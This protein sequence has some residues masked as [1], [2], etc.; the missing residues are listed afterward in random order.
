MNLVL[1]VEDEKMIRQGI[2]TMI[3]RSGVPVDVIM[4]CN[5]GQ[6]ALEILQEQ[7]VDVMFTDIRMPKVDGIE[8]VKRMQECEHVPL[9]VAISGYD[10]FS[11]AVELMR[12]GVREYL[13][14]P[15]DR[16][17]LKNILQKLEE[18]IQASKEFN[19]NIRKLGYQQLK[20]LMMNEHMSDEE[21]RLLKFQY[22]NQFYKDQYYVM[23]LENQKEDIEDSTEYIYL[24]DIEYNDVFIVESENLE[25][26]LKN[27][28]SQSCVGISRC[29]VG[30]Q[31]LKEAYE[32][33]S[34]AR[35]RAF[36][37]NLHVVDYEEYCKKKIV[38]D[39]NSEKLLSQE[40]RSQR[41]QLLGT[42]KTDDI[43][44]AWNWFYYETK[45]GNIS[46]QDFKENIE[47]FLTQIA[48][49]YR[50]SIKD[51]TAVLERLREIWKYPDLNSYEEEFMDYV[52]ELHN[53]INSQVD[54][55]KNTQ[56]IQMAVQYIQENYSKD[57]N[58]AVV[59]NYISMNYSLFSYLFKQMTGYNF[60]N[61]LKEI[62]M[63]EAKR[64]LQETDDR[65]IEISQKIGYENE[66]HF[67]KLFKSAYGVSPSEYRKNM[68]KSK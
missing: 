6:T 33:A 45:R 53:Q 54:E 14:K 7:K 12:Y 3:Q 24:H 58:M 31:E 38:R 52:L 56:K 44:S 23:C 59:S 47:L 60:V 19:Q 13:L 16:E 29:H 32:E 63:E 35:K 17:K 5:N 10:D 40:A 43:I 64:L 66:K 37:R 15:V 68:K 28:L 22:E 51:S 4:E 67:M 48:K 61:Y 39:E 1:I 9:T 55:S 49:T 27:E 20:Y 2:K 65:I 50:T 41:V 18:E 46:E 36:C 62:R 30:I 42:D 26:L 57:L 21:M 25:L 8:L 11:Y 34:L